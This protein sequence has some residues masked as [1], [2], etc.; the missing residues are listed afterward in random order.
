MA[1]PEVDLMGEPELGIRPVYPQ[2]DKQRLYSKD[3]RVWIASALNRAVEFVDPVPESVLDRFD[4]V[5]RTA[6]FNGI[7]RPSSMQE[8]GVARPRLVFDELLRIQLALVLRKRTLERRSAGIAHQVGGELVRRF[9]EQLPYELT[10]A[11]NIE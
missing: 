4:F 1:N 6:A 2:S 9:H 3:L 11:Q 10:N 8:V 5:D 7:H